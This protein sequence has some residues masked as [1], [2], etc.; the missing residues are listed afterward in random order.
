MGFLEVQEVARVKE[1]RTIGERSRNLQP[2][3]FSRSNPQFSIDRFVH[4]LSA[5]AS[6]VSAAVPDITDW[7]PVFILDDFKCFFFSYRVSRVLILA[8]IYL[9]YHF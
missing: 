6:I 3:G 1:E 8:Y 7:F 4:R 9:F 2:N 5:T